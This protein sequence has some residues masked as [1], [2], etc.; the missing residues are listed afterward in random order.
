VIHL[1]KSTHV[2]N[3]KEKKI[4]S[5][6]AYVPYV[7]YLR[8]MEQVLSA[9]TFLPTCLLPMILDYDGRLFLFSLLPRV[10]SS[11]CNHAR[12]SGHEVTYVTAP[13]CLNQR[14]RLHRTYFSEG[15]ECYVWTCSMEPCPDKGSVPKHVTYPTSW[16]LFPC[17]DTW[18]QP[19]GAHF[20]CRWV[21]FS[22]RMLPAHIDSPASLELEVVRKQNEI[23]E[24]L[25]NVEEDSL[26][27]VLIFV[28]FGIETCFEVLD[29]VEH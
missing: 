17:F 9:T 5:V 20:P 14:E 11:L 8:Y 23:D 4:K 29:M 10:M 19:E 13:N 7:P 28:L 24:R 2:E 12:G 26:I 16:H 18:E 25:W 6:L 3:F 27:D 1:K 22:P 15:A 21:H